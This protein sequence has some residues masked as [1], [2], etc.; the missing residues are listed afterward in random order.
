[1]TVNSTSEPHTNTEKRWE[2]CADFWEIFSVGSVSSVRI[3]LDS[4]STDMSEGGNHRRKEKGIGSERSMSEMLNLLCDSNTHT[5]EQGNQVSSKLSL[6]VNFLF[7]PCLNYDYSTRFSSQL[8]LTSSIPVTSAIPCFH[9]LLN[10]HGS[11]T[12][13]NESESCHVNLLTRTCCK[14][15]KTLLPVEW[16]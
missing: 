3:Q 13:R 8:S 10:Y 12:H 5:G 15:T 9:S 6:T 2:W 14:L 4:Q 11:E 7:L 1:M 16:V